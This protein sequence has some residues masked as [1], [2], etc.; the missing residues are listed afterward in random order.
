MDVEPIAEEM[1]VEK[2]QDIQSYISQELMDAEADI[3]VSYYLTSIHD[4]SALEAFSKVVQKLVHTLPVLNNLLNQLIERCGPPSLS[5]P[6]SLT[7]PPLPAA[8]R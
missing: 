4:H 6:P 1:K 7:P 3:L 2:L 8:V 5:S